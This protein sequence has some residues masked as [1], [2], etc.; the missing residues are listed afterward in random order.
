MIAYVRHI[1]N[2]LMISMADPNCGL[3]G[4]L[5]IAQ[6]QYQTGSVFVLAGKPWTPLTAEA[7]SVAAAP[8]DQGVPASAP[9]RWP[10]RLAQLDAAP[11]KNNR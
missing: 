11:H 5:S 3:C 8:A 4:I 10:H 2:S 9:A 1:T 6:H 7:L